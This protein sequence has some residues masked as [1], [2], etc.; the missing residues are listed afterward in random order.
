MS[1]SASPYVLHPTQ[2]FCSSPV[3]LAERGGLQPLL[4]MAALRQSQPGG[5]SPTGRV[6]LRPEELYPEPP[7]WEDQLCK[8]S[9]SAAPRKRRPA[10]RVDLTEPQTVCSKGPDITSFQRPSDRRTTHAQLRTETPIGLSEPE[11]QPGPAEA[12]LS[13][14]CHARE[15]NEPLVVPCGEEVLDESLEVAESDAREALVRRLETQVALL[16]G[17][18]EAIRE[19]D[20]QRRQQLVQAE[21]SVQK[22]VRE[23]SRME[24]L[25]SELSETR[26]APALPPA[27]L[28]SLE[29]A[30]ALSMLQEDRRKH[31]SRSSPQST[32]IA[33]S[34]ANSESLQPALALSS[35]QPTLRSLDQGRSPSVVSVTLRTGKPIFHS[36]LADSREEESAI[37]L[38]S[39]LE[40]LAQDTIS[41]STSVSSCSIS[42]SLS[43]EVRFRSMSPSRQLPGRR[44]RRKS[45]DSA[46]GASSNLQGRSEREPERPLQPAGFVQ[47]LEAQPAPELERND[48]GRDAQHLSDRTR[49]LEESGQSCQQLQSQAEKQQITDSVSLRSHNRDQAWQRVQDQAPLKQ[50]DKPTQHSRQTPE[51]TWHQ[52]QQRGVE[53]DAEKTGLQQDKR[54]AVLE[55]KQQRPQPHALEENML[56]CTQPPETGLDMSEEQCKLAESQ[57]EVGQDQL[58]EESQDVKPSGSESPSS[59]TWGCTTPHYRPVGRSPLRRP[60]LPPQQRSEL[61]SL[62]RQP[63]LQAQQASTQATTAASPALT[64]L[65]DTSRPAQKL[66]CGK[67]VYRKSD[68]VESL[69]ASPDCLAAG[70]SSDQEGSPGSSCVGKDES[71]ELLPLEGPQTSCQIE[72]AQR[73]LESLHEVASASRGRRTSQRMLLGAV[74]RPVYHDIQEENHEQKHESHECTEKKLNDTATED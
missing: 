22:L 73:S 14:P 60:P 59:S 70:G 31:D 13:G 54:R 39:A 7:R 42:G 19:E 33:I 35:P 28:E 21:A 12:G 65:R 10:A 1:A 53:Q 52:S 68:V 17:E 23:K 61:L 11:P 5:V 36:A 46:V 64:E 8:S 16:S 38:S 45:R 4:D 26:S 27:A 41:L 57:Q 71:P 40:D 67:A 18:L 74:T 55:R 34:S 24:Q 62:E 72:E 43:P 2:L 37:E 49:P 47:Q 51:S 56:A 50:K 63:R 25:I 29:P 3:P 44:E 48:E 30:S 69:P 20:S 9:S 15:A 66:R 58:L 32:L 6:R